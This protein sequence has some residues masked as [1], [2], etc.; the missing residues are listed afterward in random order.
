LAHGIHLLAIV[1]VAQEDRDL[2]DVGE[3]G[4]GGGQ[5]P[6]DVLVD[7]AGLGDDV[8]AAHHAPGAV[9]GHAAGDEHE[10]AGPHDMGEVAD[11]LRHAGD[12]EFLT[13]SVHERPPGGWARR[14]DATGDEG[15]SP[16]VPASRAR[17]P[18]RG[19]CWARDPSPRRRLAGPRDPRAGPP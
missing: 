4:A 5:A 3:G 10:P 18:P 17:G 8:A 11:R 12:H 13:M 14:Y 19:P 9:G 15:L 1:D 2:A 7:L 16:P 6:L